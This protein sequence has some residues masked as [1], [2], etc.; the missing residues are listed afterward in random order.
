MQSNKE[1]AVRLFDNPMYGTTHGKGMYRTA[2]FNGTADLIAPE[3]KYL[4]DFEEVVRWANRSK[5]ADDDMTCQHV[6]SNSHSNLLVSWIVR[7]DTFTKTKTR[8]SGFCTID[9]QTNKLELLIVDT[10]LG[11]EDTWQLDVKPCKAVLGKKTPQLLA[12][13]AELNKV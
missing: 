7:Y 3:L 8:V 9:L 5:N 4:L 11:V 12:T 2:V 13:N 1:I 6:L 10:E